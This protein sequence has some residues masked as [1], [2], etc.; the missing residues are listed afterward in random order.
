MRRD[1]ITSA[2]AIVVMTVLFG[3]IYPLAM[4]GVSKVVFPG[5]ANGQIL[6]V[7]GKK[8]GSKIIGQA[9]ADPVLDK[10]GKPKLTKTGGPVLNPDPRYF[11]SRPPATGEP[12]TNGGTPDNAAGTAF[13][14][15]GP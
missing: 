12:Y 13:S 2:I 7:N 5:N 15:L 1:I 8:V 14:N 6:Y 9:F 11:Q 10:N 3:V 4:T